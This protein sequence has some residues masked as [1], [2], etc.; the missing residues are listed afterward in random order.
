MV[1][2]IL[3]EIALFLIPFA[4]FLVYRSASRDLSVRDRWPLT[5]LAS[6]GAALAVLGLVLPPLFARSDEGMCYLAPR[7]EGGVRIE[8]RMVDCS[9]VSTPERPPSPPP[10]APV[11]PRDMS[12]Q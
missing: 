6:A 10:E 9:E 3:L 12:A 4:V 1:Q 7:Y 11:A 2:R 5:M 8:G